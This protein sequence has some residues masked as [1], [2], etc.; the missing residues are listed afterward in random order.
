M[1]IQKA[2]KPKGATRAFHMG[3]GKGQM[4]P[5]KIIPDRAK[6]RLEKFRVAG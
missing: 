6:I 2:G 1:S 5:V 3:S 4:T